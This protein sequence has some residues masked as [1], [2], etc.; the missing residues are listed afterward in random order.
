MTDVS[1]HHHAVLFCSYL[2]HVLDD[3]FD[4]MSRHNRSNSGN[5]VHIHV[6][7]HFLY[8]ENIY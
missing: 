3:H 2:V 4:E 5:G 8:K 1:R 7:I 6:F